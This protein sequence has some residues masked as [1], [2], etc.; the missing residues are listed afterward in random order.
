MIGRTNAGAGGGLSLKEALL[1]VNAPLGSIINFKKNNIIIKTLEP[2]KAIPNIDG[3]TADYYFSVSAQNYGTWT[4]TST[5]DGD[6]ETEDV[7]VAASQQ[8][9]VVITYAY[10]IIK[11][12][13]YQNGREFQ[14]YY[15]T[16]NVVDGEGYKQLKCGTPSVC[17]QADFTGYATLEMD[18]S[19]SVSNNWCYVG[20]ASG[21]DW[22]DHSPNA[23]FTYKNWPDTQFD[24]RIER[25]STIDISNMQY[26]KFQ[27]YGQ[28]IFTIYNMRL[29]KEVVE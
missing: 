14:S 8:Y 20:V 7:Q 9:D 21:T 15:G 12:G 28:C 19:A 4:V 3:K 10:Y 5:F 17:C 16:L 11:N 18:L 2:G 22:S 1:H 25:F 6:T 27:S 13:V 29:R 23:F 24:R 26:I